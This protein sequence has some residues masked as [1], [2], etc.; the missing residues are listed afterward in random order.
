MAV[1][2]CAIRRWWGRINGDGI[3]S[4]GATA[5][6]VRVVL[7]L[8]FGWGS[9]PVDCEPG[10]DRE[11]ASAPTVDAETKPTK[12]D[13]LDAPDCSVDPLPSR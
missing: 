2:L 8:L 10:C 3:C 1:I 7:V 12:A 11:D 13:E 5:I 6:V 4:P 9:A